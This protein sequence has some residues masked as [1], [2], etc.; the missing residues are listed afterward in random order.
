ME[1]LQ[2]R[3]TIFSSLDHRLT[4][5]AFRAP[6]GLSSPETDTCNPQP[7]LEKGAVAAKQKPVTMPDPPPPSA[8]STEEEAGIQSCCIPV[9]PHFCNSCMMSILIKLLFSALGSGNT[10]PCKK[11]VNRESRHWIWL[12]NGY[13]WRWRVGPSRMQVPQGFLPWRP[14]SCS[15]NR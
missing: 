8:T 1:N 9:Q 2:N 10:E 6:C 5:T 14:F 13:K 12:G 11:F 7:L 3:G 4:V 15:F